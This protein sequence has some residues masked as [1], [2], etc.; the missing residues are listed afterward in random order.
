MPA[1]NKEVAEQI[2][3]KRR[4]N[5]IFSS[6]LFN[7]ECREEVIHNRLNPDIFTN[8][9][10]KGFVQLFNSIAESPNPL[11]L[12]TM[13]EHRYP[14][15]DQE[16]ERVKLKSQFE[17]LKNKCNPLELEDFQFHVKVLKNQQ[18]FSKLR[19][20]ANGILDLID[21]SERNITNTKNNKVEVF[22]EQGLA[23]IGEEFDEE[24]IKAM[25]L[26]EGYQFLV[27]RINEIRDTGMI[28][29]TVTSGYAELDAI[30]S[31]G[32]RKG[33]FSIISARPSMG[34]SV[35]MMNQAIEAAKSGAKVLFMSIEMNLLQC[36]QRV[37]SNVSNVSAQHIQ[38]PMKLDPQELQQLTEAEKEISELYGQ[39]LWIEEAVSLSVPRL[40]Q[41]IRK[42]KKKYGVDLVFVDY[43]QIMKLPSGQSPEDPSDY[44]AIS[45]GLMGMAKVLDVAVVV[46]S[47]L[48]RDIEKRQD[49]RP[50]LSDLRN[51]G[52]FEQDAAAVIGLYRDFVY[53]E[54]TDE[55]NTLEFVINKN[56][57]GQGNVIVKYKYDFGKQMILPGGIAE[58][59]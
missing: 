55:P 37:V 39:N 1:I 3:G 13:I 14:H 35:V 26:A 30:L 36:F 34:K 31:G 56:R 52:S 24:E 43:A 58:A 54:N 48:T 2:E 50:M 41:R 10:I 29:E 33:N 11:T 6:M 19:G 21:E 32:Y 20:L 44:T 9:S 16:I 46:G 23:A 27:N 8:D 7:K 51:S 45:Q 4:E 40:E 5:L 28:T 47:Q 18:K 49:K 38:Q 22:M 17:K 42:Y 59:A 15:D 57:F 53:N 25:N 12:N